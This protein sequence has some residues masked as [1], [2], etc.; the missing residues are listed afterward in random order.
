MFTYLS[1]QREHFYE[2]LM[3]RRMLSS[4]ETRGRIGVSQT[5]GPTE[6]LYCKGILSRTC[7][8]FEDELGTSNDVFRQFAELLGWADAQDL[9]L[10]NKA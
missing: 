5:I 7:P 4:P 9:Q 8:G 1:S 3:V 2:L 6:G 10:I